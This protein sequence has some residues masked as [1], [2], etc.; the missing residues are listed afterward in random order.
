MDDSVNAR[1]WMEHQ[2]RAKENDR[3]YYSNGNIFD[4]LLAIVLISLGRWYYQLLEAFIDGD[5]FRLYV[6]IALCFL[7]LVLYYWWRVY[8]QMALGLALLVGLGIEAFKLFF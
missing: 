4:L 1:L 5:D 2:N 8:I 6:S 7:S 3:R